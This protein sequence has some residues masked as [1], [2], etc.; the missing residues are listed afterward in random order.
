MDLSAAVDHINRD[1]LYKSINQRLPQHNDN[2]LFRRIE[3]LYLYT[4]TTLDGNETDIFEILVGV[5]QA[6]WARI[7]G[8]IH[9][10]YG[11]FNASIST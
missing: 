7:T 4:T 11:L 1:W 10:V 6:G 9:P 8:P 3:S 5:R 2:G